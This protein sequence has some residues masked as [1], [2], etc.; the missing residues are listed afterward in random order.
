MFGEKMSF[1]LVA[2]DPMSWIYFLFIWVGIFAVWY[3]LKVRGQTPT[4]TETFADA[5]A[6]GTATAATTASATT[7]AT[8]ASGT[9]PDPAHYKEVLSGL[10]KSQALKFY[11]TSFS[12]YTMDEQKAYVPEEMKWYNFLQSSTAFKLVG[13]IPSSIRQQLEG[14]DTYTAVGFPLKAAKLI[15]P[16]SHFACGSTV[17]D[18]TVLSS[19]SA[20]FY[21]RLNSLTFTDAARETVLFQM[22]AENP[23]HIKWSIRPK[24]S[25]NSYIE[26]VLGNVYTTY[27][28][29]VP[30]S[31]LLSNGN[32]TLYALVYN[33]GTTKRTITV[34][35]GTNKYTASSTDMT[36]IR[37]GYT[38]MEI[39]SLSNLDM[40]LQSFAY[41]EN[42]LAD[43]DIP[44]WT[45]YFVQQAGGLARTLKYLK[46][47]YA[48]EI[49]TL[50]TQLLNQTNSVDDLQK[51]LEECRAKLPASLL[52]SKLEKWKI[53]MEGDATISTEDAAKCTILSTPSPWKT[54]G[55][56]VA[57]ATAA[58]ATT[59]AT[60]SATAAGAKES[61]ELSG[62]KIISPVKRG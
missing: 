17:P 54:G 44:V 3:A 33:I 5:A 50:N 62:L 40:T 59:T 61:D 1:F 47:T 60:A 13:T 45:E 21:G 30:N 38:P 51:A 23:N 34:Y 9:A 55:A 7:T 42:L 24:D 18:S 27:R 10:P 15:G 48:S 39:N 57:A 29:L 46:D 14:E 41:M 53:K 2:G 43:A 28:W 37:L 58:T 26:V 11:L 22:F 19:F 20:M 16:A 4:T 6:S 32:P 36:P 49:T 56:K 12:D 25:A 31:T 8:T 52:E 35:V